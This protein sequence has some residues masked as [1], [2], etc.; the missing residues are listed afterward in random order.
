LTGAPVILAL[1]AVHRM[2]VAARGALGRVTLHP[3]VVDATIAA[4]CYLAAAVPVAGKGASPLVL[5]GMA[6]N[7]FPLIWRRRFPVVTTIV[8]GILTTGLALL[9]AVGELP[10]AQLV[11]TYTFAMLCTPMWRLIGILGT[12]VGITVSMVLPGEKFF[13]VPVVVA[14]FGGAYALGTSARARQDRIALLEERTR[15]LAETTRRSP[16]PSGSGSPGTCTTA[17]RTP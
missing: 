3:T 2:I 1:M 13:N 8:V 17:S 4:V 10:Y 7:A 6:A 9:D 11:A 5:L 15:R 16:R 14:A 12:V